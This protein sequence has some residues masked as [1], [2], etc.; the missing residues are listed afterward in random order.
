MSINKLVY[1]KNSNSSDKKIQN[2]SASEGSVQSKK[3]ENGLKNAANAETAEHKKS[4]QTQ[5]QSYKSGKKAQVIDESVRNNTDNTS[6]IREDI[7]IQFIPSAFDDYL[8]PVAHYRND[9]FEPYDDELKIH[10]LKIRKEM[11][12]FQWTSALNDVQRAITLYRTSPIP[13]LYLIAC[14]E[15]IGNIY[16][17]FECSVKNGLSHYNEFQSALLY[18]NEEQ[19]NF[20]C[21]SN[22]NSMYNYVK[23][24]I[25]SITD[26]RKKYILIT[27]QYRYMFLFIK[28]NIISENIRKKGFAFMYR[29]CCEALANVQT[30]SE[31]EQVSQMFTQISEYGNSAEAAKKCYDIYGKI[32]LNMIQDKETPIEKLE[33]KYNE[34][35]SA[36]GIKNHQ[37]LQK[38]CQERIAISK[39]KISNPVIKQRYR[40]SQNKKSKNKKI[41]YIA[42][43]IAV[44]FIAL[45][46]AITGISLLK[47]DKYKDNSPVSVAEHSVNKETPQLPEVTTVNE[48]ENV[49]QGTTES[50][51][52]E[53]SDEPLAVDTS[54]EVK[55]ALQQYMETEAEQNSSYALYDIN[56]DGIKELFIQYPDFDGGTSSYIYIYKNGKYEKSLSFGNTYINLKKHLIMEKIYD[57]GETTKIYSLIDGEILQKDELKVLYAAETNY[58][59]NDSVISKDDY[60]NLLAEYSS[61]DWISVSDI[62]IPVSA[63][64][65]ASTNTTATTTQVT[66]TTTP[67]TTQVTS[68]TAQAATSTAKVTSATAKV[69]SATA[70]ITSTTAQV[71]STTVQ[72]TSATTTTSTNNPPTSEFIATGRIVTEN[73][74]LNLR[75][76]P[77]LN[78]EIVYQIPKGDYVG[79]YSVQGNW[80]YVK[81]YADN[82]PV[83]YGYVSKDYVDISWLDTNNT[84]VTNNTAVNDKS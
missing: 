78:S 26:P 32:V 68:A 24:Q 66:T 65:D 64:I 45:I 48:Y 70:Q 15:P 35:S 80:L 36:Y 57:S 31:A 73:D 27:S 9:L 47:D 54:E 77:D 52:Y 13:Y 58:F 38:I 11:Q 23:S 49:T 3:K 7:H 46:F 37:Q 43:C 79:I 72:I 29:F 84:P 44:A 41:L 25:V 28:N 5:N 83:Y 71:T 20:L 69:T 39:N 59:H 74:P 51:N 1:G 53:I 62:S 42:G 60:N 82:I 2:S 22:L 30:Y 76:A 4:E 50:E 10:V 6:D 67:I 56:A 21:E 16:K 55:Q 40:K 14:S 63:L 18:S 34:L 17:F 8:K 81:Y 61:I 19:R 12:Y 33:E 75:S